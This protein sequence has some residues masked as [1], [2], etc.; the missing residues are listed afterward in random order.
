MEAPLGSRRR[1]VVAVISVIAAAR[2]SDSFFAVAVHAVAVVLGLSLG[3]Q[4]AHDVAHE[5]VAEAP[6]RPHYLRHSLYDP[7]H[8][9]GSAV[10]RLLDS[11]F[12]FI[13]F[14]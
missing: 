3:H 13:S 10:D 4:R 12:P 8:G 7:A 1:R 11:G 6:L 5:R 14:R 2:D 9:L